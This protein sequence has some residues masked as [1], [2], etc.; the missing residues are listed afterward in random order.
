MI[1]RFKRSQ[2]ILPGRIGAVQ[3]PN[4][5]D[6][7]VGQRAPAFDFSNRA[8]RCGLLLPLRVRP[9]IPACS[10]DHRDSFF[11]VQNGAREIRAD[12]GLIVWMRDDNQQVRLVSLIRFGVRTVL[13]G[14]ECGAAQGSG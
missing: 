5:H 14:Y 10:E 13:R 6:A 3:E 11:L 9:F 4:I 8:E 2:N 12:R 1:P 7:K